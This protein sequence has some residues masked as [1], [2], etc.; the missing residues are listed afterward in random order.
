MGLRQSNKEARRQRILEAAGRLLK[1]SGAE[2]LTMR[3]LAREADVAEMTPYNLFGSKGDVVVA[4]FEATVGHVVERSFAEIPS[5]PIERLFVSVDVLADTWTAT[6]GMFREL[7]RCARESGADLTRFSETPI[8]LLE[9]GL[10]D[11]QAAG[12]ITGDV[13]LTA[14]ARHI[15]FSNQ[16]AYEPWVAGE[17]DEA[18][19]RASLVLGLS[20][21]LLSVATPDTR[22][23][24]LDRLKKAERKGLPPK[25][26]RRGS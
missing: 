16:G 15:F 4:L 21:A 2:G 10:A 1:R 13:P 24:V 12:Q 9:S 26:T 18:T 25:R 7:M 11:A 3:E 23:R 20:I 19:L 14:L 5:D 8:S 22:T 17:I 6:D